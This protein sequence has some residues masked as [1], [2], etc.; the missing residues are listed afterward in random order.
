MKNKFQI[1]DKQNCKIFKLQKNK[2]EIF[3]LKPIMITKEEF[4]RL[5][6]E[7]KPTNALKKLMQ[8]D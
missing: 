7:S 4:E 3:L 6:K 5:E 2:K 1:Y 8:N